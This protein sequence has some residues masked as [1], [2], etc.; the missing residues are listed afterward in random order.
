MMASLVLAMQDVLTCSNTILEGE[1]RSMVA[2]ESTD[3]L[4]GLAVTLFRP[5][6]DV[7][8]LLTLIVL[9]GVSCDKLSGFTC[10][11]STRIGVDVDGR[12]QR[13]SIETKF[14]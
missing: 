13:S 9:C 14:L 10:G 6:S 11:T 1:Q 3:T 2:R 8:R 4:A 5:D 7:G 12:L